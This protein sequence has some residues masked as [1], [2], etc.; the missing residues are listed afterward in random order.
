MDHDGCWGNPIGSCIDT[1]DRKQAHVEG[2]IPLHE[3]ADQ[4][5]SHATAGS[6][7]ATSHM[8]RTG[9]TRFESG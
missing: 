8:M 3:S 9:E 4:A 1:T 7:G 5:S 6:P 2:S